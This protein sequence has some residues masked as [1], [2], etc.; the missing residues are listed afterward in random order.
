MGYTVHQV[1]IELSAEAL[2]TARVR[3]GRCLLVAV[4]YGNFF[5][6][7]LV[8]QFLGLMDAVG[9][10]GGI[11]GLAVKTRGVGVSDTGRAGGN[12]EDLITVGLSGGSSGSFL[13]ELSGFL[14][15]DDV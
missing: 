7:D 15:V 4:E 9:N 2:V 11:D 5:V 10:L 8:D 12:S 13:G 1:L 3:A 6:D 14:L